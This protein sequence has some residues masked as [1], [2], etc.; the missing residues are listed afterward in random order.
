LLCDVRIALGVGF[1]VPLLFLTPIIH[2]SFLF[3]W[4]AVRIL[5]TADV[6]SGYDIPWN[7]L[8]FI[9]YYGGAIAH[10][11]HHAKSN[12]NFSSTFTWWDTWCGTT[13]YADDNYLSLKPGKTMTSSTVKAVPVGIATVNGMAPL[14]STLPA[15]KQK[16]LRDQPELF[17][18]SN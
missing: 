15:N 4:L 16:Q 8:R 11:L 12:G 9:P 10:D 1:F 14:S 2:V 6:H 3:I 7:P 5:E 18:K 13:L 17:E